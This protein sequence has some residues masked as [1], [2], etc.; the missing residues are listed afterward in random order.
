MK[1]KAL[2]KFLIMLRKIIFLTERKSLMRHCFNTI[3][4]FLLTCCLGFAEDTAE[5]LE[6][7][8]LSILHYKSEDIE[9][10]D[11]ALSAEC[12]PLTTVGGCINVISGHFFQADQDLIG[13]TIDPLRLTRYY[14]SAN[15][16]ETFLGT[17]FGS[18]YPLLAS[19]SQNG[20]RH[21]YVLISERDGFLIPY[22]CKLDDHHYRI[23]PRLL[24]KGYTNLSRVGISGHANFVNWQALWQLNGWGLQLGDGTKRFYT[25]LIELERIEKMKLKLPSK[26]VYL[27]TKEEKPNGNKVNFDYDDEHRLS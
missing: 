5:Y 17:G 11:I 27:L 7:L 16:M 12:E 14:D 8:P 6:C 15:C 23:D 26:K 3:F 19:K 2:A 25:K 24:E 4:L 21:N 10:M 18:Q 9:K 20:T 22:R 1:I 13:N